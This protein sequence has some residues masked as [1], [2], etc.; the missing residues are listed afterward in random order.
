VDEMDSETHRNA[1]SHAQIPQDSNAHTG[2]RVRARNQR[3]VLFLVSSGLLGGGEVGRCAQRCF[4]Y[5]VQV[6]EKERN[7]FASCFPAVRSGR[8]DDQESPSLVILWPILRVAR[9]FLRN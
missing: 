5:T 2:K 8:G 6:A 3:S 7:L 1:H 9:P 4:G